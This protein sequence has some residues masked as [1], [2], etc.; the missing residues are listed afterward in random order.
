MVFRT[1]YSN[2]NCNFLYYLLCPRP[3][4]HIKDLERKFFI[5]NIIAEWRSQM[6]VEINICTFFVTIA[7][8]NVLLKLII[9]S[10]HKYY[11]LWLL[12]HLRTL[13]FPVYVA[14][15]NFADSFKW[16][17]TFCVFPT[18]LQFHGC[19]VATLLMSSIFPAWKIK[20]KKI[21]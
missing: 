10:N 21:I 5:F 2:C 13:F 17:K 6:F 14:K 11:K 16:I 18:Q 9:S 12:S 1:L 15:S 20:R 4:G 3:D 8:R 19:C 7:I